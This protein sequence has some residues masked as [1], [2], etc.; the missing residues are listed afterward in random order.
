[1]ARHVVILG[2]GTGGTL[3]ANWLRRRFR[4]DELAITVVDQHTPK[5]KE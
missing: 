4:P 1:M 2:G 3:A 5:T